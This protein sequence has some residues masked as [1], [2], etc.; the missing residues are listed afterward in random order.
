M[1]GKVLPFLL[2]FYFLQAGFRPHDVVKLT[3]Q[4]VQQEIV[5]VVQQFNQLIPGNTVSH[6]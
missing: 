6:F 1:V 2:L 5:A 3:P 4:E